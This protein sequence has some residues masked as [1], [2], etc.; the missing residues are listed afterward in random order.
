MKRVVVGLSGG[1]DSSVTAYLLKEQGYEVI[2][3]FMK[4]WHD[5]SVTISDDCPWLEDSNDAMLVAEKLGIPF[6]TVDLSDQYKERIVDYMFNEYEKGR[7]PNPDIL[8]NREIKFDVFMDIALSLGADY[9][10]TGHYCRKAEEVIDG[11]AVYKL[12]AGKDANKDQSYF[13]CQLSQKQL[14]KAMFPI[15]ELTK[16]EVREIAKKAD[17]ITADKKD[18]QGLCFIGKVRLPDFLQQKLQPKE[19]V[20]VQ[21]PTSFEQYNREI[22]QFENKEAELAY[23]A[24]KFSYKKESGKTVGKHQG[25]HYFTKGQRKGLNVGGTKEALYV[26]ETDVNENIIY[27]GE[28]KTHQ[29]LYRNVLFVS[30]EELH[31]VR[32]DLALKS[33]ETMEVEARIR[34]RQKLEKAI[35]H[36]VDSGLYVEFENKQSAIQ[37]GQFVA[38]YINEELVGSGVIS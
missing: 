37:E 25:A 31:A 5:D 16:P 26:I 32:E 30:N 20:I 8:C 28:G 2:G 33:G 18:S 12:L 15:G 17:L 27:T 11:E 10:A 34:Y 1:V 24:T 7:T 22:P 9:V 4:N 13:L 29:G 35:L 36:K 3:L 23:F 14:A 38:W 21:I 6:Q 19:G